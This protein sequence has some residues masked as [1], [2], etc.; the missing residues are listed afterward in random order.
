ML[1]D[2]R[3]G[4]AMP[5]VIDLDGVQRKAEALLGGPLEPLACQLLDLVARIRRTEVLEEL[6]VALMS[7]VPGEAMVPLE[8]R[9]VEV[10]DE[11]WPAR[12]RQVVV[13][14]SPPVDIIDSYGQ[15]L[16]ISGPVAG[17]L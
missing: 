5:A 14:P 1:N 9:H 8:A 2:D 13:H 16:R 4:P 10:L 3:P 17:V 6:V 15:K 7:R 11:L 12:P